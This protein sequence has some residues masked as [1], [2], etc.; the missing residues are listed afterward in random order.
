MTT[1]LVTVYVLALSGLGIFG[2]LGYVTLWYFWRHRADPRPAA[3]EPAAGAWPRV[4][5]QL[6]VFNERYVIRR[7]VDAAAALDYPRE[8]L[9]IQVL[10]DSTDETTSLASV[11]VEQMRGRGF[12]IDLLHRRQRAGYKAGAL[13]AG[14]TEAE[15]DFLAIFDADFQPPPEFL[16]QTIPLFV[17][18]PNLGMVQ[19]RWGHLNDGHSALTAAQAIA[20]DKHF[21]I[22]QTVRHRADFYPK[23]NGTA[24][25]W[26]RRCIEDAGGWRDDTVCE[27]LCLSTRAIL[28]GWDFQ[29]LPDVVTP[30]ELPTSISAYKNQQ[31][32]WA[33]GS[34]QCLIKFGP[35]ILGDRQHT[36]LARLYALI[37]MSGYL[38]HPLLLTLILLQIPLLALGYPLTSRLMFFSLLGLGQPL[39]F[40]ISQQLVY[41]DWRRRLRHL[42]TLLIITLGLGPSITRAMFEI[43]LRRPHP[44]I[45]TPKGAGRPDRKQARRFDGYRLPFDWIVLVE[46]ALAAYGAAGLVLALTAGIFGP[47]FLLSFCLIGFSTVAWL[48][49]RE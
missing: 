48:S 35:A 22:E 13:E 17:Q 7:L 26:R 34:L 44:F 21:I 45:R 36:L 14:L 41:P 15:G 23:F 42:P 33:K 43:L 29:F 30:G 40:I 47:V 25:V 1:L 27:D 4:T 9:Q 31:A 49:L 19:T 5:V 10:D 2:L 16:K 28:N 38:A 24:G 18:D 39:L 46:L 20:M 11:M 6:P 37:A 8:R 32:R 12:R 3:P